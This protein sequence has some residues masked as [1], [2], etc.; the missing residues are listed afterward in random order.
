M[1]LGGQVELEPQQKHP[2]CDGQLRLQEQD[3][4]CRDLA[5]SAALS[6]DKCEN[7]IDEETV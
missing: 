3:E 2:G 1:D 6:C 4:E 5:V 7:R